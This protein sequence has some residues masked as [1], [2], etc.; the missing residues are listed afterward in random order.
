[1]LPDVRKKTAALLV[2]AVFLLCG[3]G[4]AYAFVIRKDTIK[5]QIINATDSS[6]GVLV[7]TV[8]C[9]T[10]ENKIT[11]GKH[12]I[13]RA[14]FDRIYS[15]IESIKNPDF[16]DNREDNYTLY[17]K[18]YEDHTYLGRIKVTC[19]SELNGLDYQTHDVVRTVDIFDEYPEGFDEF[20]KLINEIEP[21]EPV[22]TG[23]PL[24]MS[25]ELY[26][27]LTGFTDDMV[28]DGTVED[29]LRVYPVD[30]YHLMTR[31]AD[32]SLNYSIR[33]DIPV[34]KVFRYWPLFRSLP[35]KIK[36]VDSSEAEFRDFVKKLATAIGADPDKETYENSDRTLRE[37]KFTVYVY[38]SCAM[39]DRF[40]YS[41]TVPRH[42]VRHEYYDGK[43]LD[44]DE[45]RSFFY[46]TDGK[47]VIAVNGCLE[48]SWFSD[49]LKPEE[50]MGFYNKIADLVEK[51]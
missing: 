36:M 21:E 23:K 40:Q 10:D 8:D 39:P 24:I 28:T 38:R 3:C 35:V 12:L 33:Q 29:V 6:N 51:N 14:Q 32:H 30:L 31:Y 17:S 4:K 5:V 22:M 2:A 18:A 26:K 11:E 25:S 48:R 49:Q 46:S 47:F 34:R 20:I 19:V 37:S 1:M 42:L 13:T 9:V 43:E 45:R 27:K 44:K 15:Y 16:L 50:L 7:K 41:L